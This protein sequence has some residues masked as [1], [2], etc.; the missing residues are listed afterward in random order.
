MRICAPFAGIVHYLVA[1]GT[2]V[3]TGDV[4]AMVESVK[5][6]AALPAPG[7]GTVTRHLAT[8]FDDVQGGDPLLEIEA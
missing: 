6:E 8:D 5:L 1:P 4:V 7:P 2:P 3:E